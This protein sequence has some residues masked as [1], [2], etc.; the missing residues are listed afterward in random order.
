[1]TLHDAIEKL[2]QQ[3]GRPM[4]A[5]EIADELNK[6][7]WYV[8]NDQSEIKTNQITA[9]VD[10]HHEL[11]D[12]DRSVS[13][14]QIKLYDRQLK[15]MTVFTKIEKIVEKK[16]I[17]KANFSNSKTSFDPISNFDT[18]ILILGT[19]PGDKSLELGEYYGHSGNKFWKVIS[20]ITNNVLPLTYADKQAL[21]IKTK[22]GVWDVAHKANRN[23]SLDSAIEDEVP[24]DLDS[25]ISELKN[26]RVIGFNGS[27]SQA[28][29]D[30]YF[31]RNPHIKY[32]SLPS[33]SPA[34]T[35]ITF[36]NMC[37]QWRQILN[38]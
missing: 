12:I 32:F 22:I 5:R 21:L 14:N 6:N 23:G 36:D 17:V 2:L 3:T 38:N 24:N 25:L 37:N 15:P 28:L 18:T 29:F 1:M 34:N 10:D 13:P 7:K 20:K 8:K 33:T 19:L 4:T 31:N 9:R 26:L 27:K 35:G 30:K 11:F 16:P